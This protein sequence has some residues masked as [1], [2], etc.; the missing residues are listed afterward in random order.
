MNQ[1]IIAID[2]DGTIVEDKYPAIGAMQPKAQS[3]IKSL[4]DRGDYIIIWT[5]RT[6][7]HLLQA[8]NWLVRHNIPFDAVNSHNPDNLA[9]FGGS[10]TKVYADH[11][12]DDKG[13]G[14]FP[15]WHH[16]EAHLIHGHRLTIEIGDKIINEFC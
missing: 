14:G 13:L 10:P 6:G 7:D 8:I 2:F 16:V 11:Y 15:G 9:D 3:V 12:I 1:L 4:K 5:C